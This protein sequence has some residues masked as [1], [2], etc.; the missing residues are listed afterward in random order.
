MCLSFDIPFAD[1]KTMILSLKNSVKESSIIGQL[2]QIIFFITY[3]LFLCNKSIYIP[4]KI[5]RNERIS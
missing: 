2:F 4:T 1:L 3:F 5:G